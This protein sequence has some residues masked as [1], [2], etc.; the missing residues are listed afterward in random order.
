MAH[1][2]VFTVEGDLISR[3]EIFDEADLDAALARFEELQPQAPR[4]E[5]AASQVYERSSAFAAANWD[6]IATML[7]ADAYSDDRR[8]CATAAQRRS[9]CGQYLRRS[10]T[11]ITDAISDSH[12]LALVPDTS[13]CGHAEPDVPRRAAQLVEIDA[14]DRITSAHRV[15]PRRHRR[16]LRRTRRPLPRRRSWPPTRTRGRSSRGLTTRSTDTKYPA[17]DWVTIDHRRL[18][19]ADASDRSA[20]HPRSLEHHARPQHPHRGGASAQ[21]SRSGRHPRTA[22]DLAGRL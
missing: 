17:T 3:C 22:W 6:A 21:Q 20:L 10:A 19:T 14:E 12:S 15:R 1:G 8:R 9:R 7:T 2:D 5:N 18:I 11:A 13:L 4:L 16:C